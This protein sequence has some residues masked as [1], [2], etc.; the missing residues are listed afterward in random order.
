MKNGAVFVMKS[1]RIVIRKL[2]TTTTSFLEVQRDHSVKLW[3][4]SGEH[5]KRPE[6][7]LQLISISY[8]SSTLEIIRRR[9]FTKGEMVNDFVYEHHPRL[10]LPTLQRKQRI[11]S[12]RICVDGNLKG[13][14]IFYSRK[15]FIKSGEGSRDG[16]PYDFSYDYR[17]KPKFDDE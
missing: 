11:P 6:S 15:G 1:N 4:Y 12:V 13:Q 2:K 8:Y 5:T 3:Q 9:E 16:Q 14:K 7:D 10:R 17:R